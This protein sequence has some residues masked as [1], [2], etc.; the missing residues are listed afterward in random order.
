MPR[1]HAARRSYAPD[2]FLAFREL[3]YSSGVE[4]LAPL[5]GLRPGTLYN[6]ADAGDETH[7]QPTLRDLLLATQATGD[8]RVID[9][10]N[11]TFGRAAYDC[12]QHEETTDEALL[13]LLAE[14]GAETGDFHRAMAQ[15]LAARRFTPEQMRQIRG[16]AFDMVS[17]LM[18][19]VQRLEGYVDE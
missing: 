14:L 17:A 2:V 18:V 11:E 12:A 15:G 5:M 3:V 10:L 8:M 16:E 1:N 6:K 9:A 4:R 19:L 13:Q 7:N